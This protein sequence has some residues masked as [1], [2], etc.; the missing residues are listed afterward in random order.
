MNNSTTF[1]KNLINIQDDLLRFAY[2]LTSDKED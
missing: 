1:T 2:R